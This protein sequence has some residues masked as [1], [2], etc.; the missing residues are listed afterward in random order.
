MLKIIK[1]FPILNQYIYAN[2]AAY[3]IMYDSL[4]DWRQE[5]DLDYLLGGS[6][7]KLKGLSLIEDTRKTVGNFFNCTIDNVALIQNV[8]LGFN[9]LLEGLDKNNKVLL[10]EGDFPS[11]NWPFE[12]RGFDVNFASLKEGILEDNIH[13]IIKNKGI[14]VLAISIVQWLNGIKIE[15]DFLKKLKSE[16]PDLLI[17][18]DGTQYCGTEVFD[19]EASAIDVLGASAYKWLL[20][21]SG[22]GFMLF[23]DEV[24]EH[25][26]LN[27]TG[28][29]SSAGVIENKNKFDFVKHFEPGHLDT[30][31]FGS[32]KRSL[33]YLTEIGKEDIEA[34]IKELGDYAF[35]EFSKLGVLE[36][37]VVKRTSHSTIF[38]IKGNQKL[39]D[40]LTNNA[41]IC[42]QRGDGIRLSFHFYITIKNIKKVVD[43]IKKNS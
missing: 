6:N 24:K 18:A 9:V 36:D 35:A 41:I 34:T 37:T 27:T 21:G 5:H 40:A 32:L 7:F 30:L 39:F 43:V 15:L 22:N 33:D 26:K 17:I 28:F 19:F 13:S 23:K 3:G 8:S 29:N 16:F 1:E 10:L 14:S 20:A 4:L 31:S 2:T 42:S 12:S 25:F 11:L 38:N